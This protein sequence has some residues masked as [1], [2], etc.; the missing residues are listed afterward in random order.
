VGISSPLHDLFCWV[1]QFSSLAS[2]RYQVDTRDQD[3]LIIIIIIILYFFILF[4][5]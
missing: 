4:N 2:G 3:S 5:L 1:F